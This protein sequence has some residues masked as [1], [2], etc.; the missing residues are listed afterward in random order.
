[1]G[2]K[3]VDVPV[4]RE[5]EVPHIVTVEKRVEV[6]QHH[7][8]VREVEVPQIQ[9]VTG[10]T[11][12]LSIPAA[13][14]RRVDN[15]EHVHVNEVGEDHPTVM[16]SMMVQAAPPMTQSVVMAAPP[17]TQSVVMAAPPMTYAAAPQVQYVQ[18]QPQMTY[19]APVTY[20]AAP[21]V[22]YV[23]EQPQIQYEQPQMTYAAAPVTY[24]APQ[25]MYQEVQYATTEQVAVAGTAH[26]GGAV[27]SVPR[28]SHGMP[29]E[30][31]A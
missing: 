31:M 19:A 29:T 7:E 14:H 18:E 28:H 1:M 24:A 13:G 30:P 10:D 21:Q 25:E 9:H 23:Q 22:Q 27:Y 3:C 8:V 20:A 26:T 11:K 16:T 4:V 6:V 15:A 17:M 12:H 2:E 5:I